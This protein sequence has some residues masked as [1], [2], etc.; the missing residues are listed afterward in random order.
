MLIKSFI[1]KIKSWIQQSPSPSAMKWSVLS[2]CIFGISTQTIFRCFEN[3]ESFSDWFQFIIEGS[4]G[5][6]TIL[7]IYI[8][9]LAIGMITVLHPRQKAGFA[10]ALFYPWINIATSAFFAILIGWKGVIFLIVG[11]AIMFPLSSFG[12]I[13]TWLFLRYKK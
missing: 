7:Y 12:G 5:V 6:L 10:G 3:K 2:G 13:C 8:L 11:L 1:Q 4:M 9:P